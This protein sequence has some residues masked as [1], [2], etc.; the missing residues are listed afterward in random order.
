MATGKRF[1]LPDTLNSKITYFSHFK[2][3]DCSKSAGKQ[4]ACAAEAGANFS[5][6]AISYSQQQTSTLNNSFEQLSKQS[7][8][9]RAQT[10]SNNDFLIFLLA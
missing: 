6:E 2:S 10:Y 7:D 3:V 8:V 5:K 9:R 4:A 1:F